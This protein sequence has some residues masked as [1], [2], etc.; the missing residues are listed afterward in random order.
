[1]PYI[2]YMMSFIRL[3]TIIF[4]SIYYWNLILLCMH[5]KDYCLLIRKLVGPKV[6]IIRKIIKISLKYHH[7]QD[8]MIRLVTTWKDYMLLKIFYATSKLWSSLVILYNIRL[9][10]IIAVPYILNIR[11]E[12]TRPPL[13]S[14]YFPQIISNCILIVS[15]LTIIKTCVCLAFAY[16]WL[17]SFVHNLF[18]KYCSV[19]C[20]NNLNL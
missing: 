18:F 9:S 11:F 1:M 12:I 15:Y 16:C 3:Q 5:E 20:E 6:L 7:P 17:T 4:L 19:H 2:F 10:N 8:M 14:F 13:L